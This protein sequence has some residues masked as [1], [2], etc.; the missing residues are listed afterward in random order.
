MFTPEDLRQADIFSC[1]DEAERARLAQ[2]IADV[3]L[4]RGEWLFQAK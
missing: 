1:L 4:E 2:T 3:R